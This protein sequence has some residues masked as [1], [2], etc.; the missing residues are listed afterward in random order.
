MHDLPFKELFVT[1]AGETK[2]LKHLHSQVI[3][4]FAMQMIHSSGKVNHL[5]ET[6]CQ[7][8]QRKNHVAVTQVQRQSTGET[9]SGGQL[10]THQPKHTPCVHTK[11]QLV[12]GLLGPRAS[13]SLGCNVLLL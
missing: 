7:C 9:C 3:Y 13:A 10:K 12:R 11:W 5:L 2:E 4:Y 6:T 8:K 1:V